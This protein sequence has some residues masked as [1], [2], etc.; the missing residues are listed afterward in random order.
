MKNKKSIKNDHDDDEK[1]M[2]RIEAVTKQ[3][4]SASRKK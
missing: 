2:K 3:N 1:K 4:L